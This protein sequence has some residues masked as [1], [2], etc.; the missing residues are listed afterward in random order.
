MR[1]SR[2]TGT[3]RHRRGAPERLA[4]Y[5]HI[6]L[7]PCEGVSSKHAGADFFDAV[8]RRGDLVDALINLRPPPGLEGRTDVVRLL[9][10]LLRLLARPIHIFGQHAAVLGSGAEA[11]RAVGVLHMDHD[12]AVRGQLRAEARVHVPPSC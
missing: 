8:K 5:G 2:I 3:A 10:E 4:H 9:F 12:R 7:G 11:G 1:K 6:R